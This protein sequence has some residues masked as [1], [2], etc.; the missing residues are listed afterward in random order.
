MDERVVAVGCHSLP[1]ALSG[2]ICCPARPRSPPTSEGR[3]PSP[4]PQQGRSLGA[5]H[6]PVG[7]PEQLGHRMHLRASDVGR[8][9]FRACPVLVTRSLSFVE[10]LPYCPY[11]LPNCPSLRAPSSALP[12]I[13]EAYAGSEAALT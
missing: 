7:I 5:C 11:H 2:R 13:A 4:V 12:A 8:G 10:L 3:Q 9:A 1:A 6:A